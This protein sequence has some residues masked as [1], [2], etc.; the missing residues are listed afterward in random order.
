MK[1]LIHGLWPE[2]N[3]IELKDC[4]RDKKLDP[5]VYG[6]VNYILFDDIYFYFTLH[7]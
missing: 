4:D 7:A 3:G 2:K 1:I 5:P 6:D